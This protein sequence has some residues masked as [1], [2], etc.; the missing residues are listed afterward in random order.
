MGMF[1]PAEE[2]PQQLQ[3]LALHLQQIAK[4]KTPPP[5]G[6]RTKVV[7][8][9]GGHQDV[10]ASFL[11]RIFGPTSALLAWSFT[12]VNPDDAPSLCGDPGLANLEPSL[13]LPD[14]AA[15]SPLDSNFDNLPG[16]LDIDFNE[17]VTILG[18]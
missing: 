11:L 10:D 4:G 14:A 6:R 5:T 8:R 16:S 7:L 15:V 12:S 17:L 2:I 1:Y 13:L 9:N 18:L 3:Q